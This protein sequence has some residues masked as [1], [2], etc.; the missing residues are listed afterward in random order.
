MQ[1]SIRS[2]IVKSLAG[3]LVGFSTLTVTAAD[4]GVS[5]F[6]LSPTTVTIVEGDT[7]SWYD[8]DEDFAPYLISGAWGSFYTPGGVQFNVAGSYPYTAQSIYFGGS[9]G[10]TVNVNPGVPNAPPVVSITQPATN[11]VF[12]APASFAFEADAS[13]VN[14]GVWDVEFWVGNV[15]VDD[16]YDPP[17]ATTVTNL[18]AGVYTLKAVAWD[19]GY[20]TAT[21]SITITVVNP[22]PI[23]LTGSALTGGNFRFTAGGLTIG[24]TNV[25]Q[26]STNLASPISWV[27]LSSNVAAS[28]TASFT[29]AVAVRQRF[30][31][32]VQ[33]P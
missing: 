2:H 8:E 5:L 4:V 23:T 29:N 18:P 13:D 11:A 26:S 14:P 24:K 9:W 31:R 33:L 12:T 16:V 27:S 7:V 17:Y 1:R 21:N 20:L 15:M 25:L 28:A 22:G 3:V 30:F 19:Y 10:G 6:G 32:V